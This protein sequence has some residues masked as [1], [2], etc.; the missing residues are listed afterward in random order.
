MKLKTVEF[1]KKERNYGE[2]NRI[3]KLPELIE[4]KKA[5][6]KFE[7]SVLTLDSSKGK[8]RQDQSRN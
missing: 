7:D 4:V 3:I 2:V 8:R 1:L 5:S 6:A